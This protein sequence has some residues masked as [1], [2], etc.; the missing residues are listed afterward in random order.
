M[1]DTAQTIKEMAAQ[2]A[3]LQQKIV[4]LERENKILREENTLLKRGRFGRSSERIALGQLALFEAGQSAPAEPET[5]AVPQHERR[6]S[7][8][9]RSPFAKDL[10]RVTIECD[11]PEGER[12]CPG[13]GKCMQ[14]IGEDVSERGH[15]IP[16]RVVVNR[17]V[18]KKYA[19]PDGHG[20]LTAAA[21]NG[22]IDGAKYEASVFS[23]VATSK[24]C[25]HVP[26]N[27]LEGILKRQG[28]HLPKQTMWDMLVRVDELV[29]QPV[30]AQMRSE[31]LEEG[32]LLADETPVTMRVE[33]GK[34]SR[35]SFGWCWRN[36]GEDNETKI[37]MEFRTSR[38]RDGPRD[39]LGKQWTGTLL[40]DGYAG[41]EQV[42]AENSLVRAG[43]WAHARRKCKEA[44]DAGS[45]EAVE[46][47]RPMHRLFW[48]ERA[49]RQRAKRDKLNYKAL[50]SLRGRVRAKRSRVVVE[51]IHEIAIDL[52]G[53]RATLP[54][55]KLGKALAYLDSQRER[56]VVFLEDSRL[57]NHNNATEL[58]IRH[59]AI[60]RKNWLLFASERGGEVACRLYS[61]VL[62]CRHNGVDPQAYIEDV[63]HKVSTTPASQIA[64]L[65]PWAWARE[66]AAS[67]Q[68]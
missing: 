6:K 48:I 34:G 29:A 7:G 18:R 49:V 4:A 14:A 65:T 39:F 2:V 45:R 5:I 31:L 59:L 55:S 38:G 22:V 60:G 30:L 58:V 8:H 50:L 66:R 61:L 54:K 33:D 27:R 43:C 37:V 26:L 17:Y 62:S 19:C 53:R 36:I 23:F 67:E 10:P 35:K 20:V 44:L 11:V 41:Y 15:I 56:L 24:Y 57:P 21:P 12:T 25:D 40:V 1:L 13:C 52:A 47:L 51:K 3:A 64:S 32:V 46:L 42:V 68:G 28:L 16:A 9:G 63:L